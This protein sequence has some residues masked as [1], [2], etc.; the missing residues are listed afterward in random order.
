MVTAALSARRPDVVVTQLH[1][2][3]AALA[4]AAGAGVP[5]VLV[6]PSYESLCKLAFDPGSDCPPDRDC[7]SCPAA[8]RLTPAERAALAASR[9]A[10]GEALAGA[11]AIVALSAAV[12][13][14]VRRWA[15]RE[16]AVVHPVG[17]VLPAQAGASS[18]GP[19]VSAAARWGV[20]KGAALLPALVAAS[21]KAGA[22]SVLVTGAG[23]GTRER[24]AIGGAGGT[25]VPTG[26]IDELLAGA[27]LV[28]VPSQWEEPFGRIAWEALARGIP[29]LASDAG[30]LAE[31]VPAELRIAPRDRLA[32]WEEAIGRLLYDPAAWAAAAGAARSAAA[33]LLDPPP[34][35]RLE[36]LL[37]AA[38]RNA[39]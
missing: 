32:V 2:A 5:G 3:P 29:V 35:D 28:L 19:V 30:G 37:A 34:L 27:S 13:T 6:V 22:R 14:I 4:A 20:Q 17:P 7:V 8:R 24:R 15:G 10:Q 11:R 9:S 18:D 33:R 38:A 16:A 12:A 23:L 25:V 26:P 1:G 39:G 21:R 36:G 31:F